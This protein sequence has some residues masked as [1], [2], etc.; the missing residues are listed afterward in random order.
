MTQANLRFVVTHANARY[1]RPD[2]TLIE[3]ASGIASAVFIIRRGSVTGVH[4]LA[5]V[6]G[7]AF[8]YEAG[9][10]FPVSAVLSAR[11]VSA[12]YRATS[13]TFVWMLPT[14]HVNTL[15][16]TCPV[17]AD[18]INGRVLHFLQMS[19]D[20]LRQS[21][22]AR[23]MLE[24][25]LER[26][27]AR[28]MHTQPLICAP[29][30]SLTQALSQMHERR[31][32][33]MLVVGQQSELLGILTRYDILSKITLA[34]VP[35]S[36]A[37]EQVMTSPVHALTDEH[38]AQDA[39]LLMSRHGVRHVPVTRSS[40]VV[41][42]VSERDLF[43]LQRL[44]IKQISTA[45]RASADV[46]SLAHCA[47]DIRDLAKDLLAQ[48]VHSRQLTG[49]ISHLNDVLTQQL[50]TLTAK[51]HG[52]SA[53]EFCWI[54]LGSEGRGEQTIS[55]DQD[56]ALILSN[57][58]SAGDVSRLM[59]MAKDVNMAL[60]ACGFPLC[61]GGIMAS[62]P[63]CC[64]RLDQ[65]KTRFEEWVQFGT[66]EHLLNASIFF[67]FR[68]LCGKSALADELRAH[69]TPLAKGSR[70]FLNLLAVNGLS[71]D[72]PL[73]WLG[74]VDTTKHNGVATIDLKLQGTA[75]VV[76]AARV[77]ALAFGI[78]ATATAQR[79]QAFG[80][81]ANVPQHEYEA[82]VT[83]FEF[84]QTLRLRVQ[85]E[86]GSEPTTPQNPLTRAH[87]KLAVDSDQPNRVSVEAL[88]DVD[89]RMLKESMKVARSIQQRLSM[90][91]AR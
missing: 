28:V 70:K 15:A 31:V 50:V 53:N 59:M 11:A 22:S 16:Q 75:L 88:N 73:N 8:E 46:P 42:I 67:D 49:L 82:W 19:R 48:G 57:E 52:V 43:A 87:P 60:D 6:V 54:A 39:A 29:S 1:F 14:V 47:S 21:Y 77:F 38:T 33:S 62:E 66:P 4:G 32:G 81:M 26:P 51:A 13:D 76:T 3:P 69:V 58:A 63:Q 2:E 71:I 91:Y 84:L 61:E 65:W 40:A 68:S 24:Q 23:S 78:E 20:A 25:S 41:G 12:H 5:D 30:T 34:Q 7:N 79:L 35:L 10:V 83:G 72:V 56:N 44:S 90:D 64:M 9:D 45:I 86:L 36:T 74:A 37:I 89:R 80:R 17:F 55:T 27:L 85:L 18:F